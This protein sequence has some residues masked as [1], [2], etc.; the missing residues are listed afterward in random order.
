MRHLV[1]QQESH[2]NRDLAHR[3]RSFMPWALG[4]LLALAMAVSLVVRQ[5]EVIAAQRRLAELQDEVQR[6]T[7]LNQSL[8]NQIQ[9]L[10]SNEYIEKTAREK[11]GLVKPGEVQYMPVVNGK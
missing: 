5:S 1:V 2:V 9:V 4:T 6:Y 11:L 7:A 3:K 8:E 10:G